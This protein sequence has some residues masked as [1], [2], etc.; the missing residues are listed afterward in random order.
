M[1]CQ[2]CF[3]HL[4][5]KQLLLFH[6][7][8]AF[9]PI[10]SLAAHCRGRASYFFLDKKVTKKSSRWKGFFAAQGLPHKSLLHEPGVHSQPQLF[11]PKLFPRRPLRFFTLLLIKGLH[12]IR[13]NYFSFLVRPSASGEIRQND[14]GLVRL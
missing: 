2:A 11:W 7:P 13:N 10:A 5:Y 1:S 3:R 4:T 14:A 9:L 6:S 8:V 12:P